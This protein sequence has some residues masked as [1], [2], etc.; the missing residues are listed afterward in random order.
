MSQLACGWLPAGGP[1]QWHTTFGG[2]SAR[3]PV[4]AGQCSTCLRLILVFA[5]SSIS[6]SLERMCCAAGAAGN[7]SAG[8]R[9]FVPALMLIGKHVLHM[10]LADV[11]SSTSAL[12]LFLKVPA[13]ADAAYN[14]KLAAQQQLETEAMKLPAS[15]HWSIPAGESTDAHCR[16]NFS[17]V[18]VLLICLPPLSHWSRPERV[19]AAAR[20][21]PF[22]VGC[23]V[24]H[25]IPPCTTADFHWQVSVCPAGSQ[26]GTGGG[27]STP[28]L[29]VVGS[30]AAS[31]RPTRASP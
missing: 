13:L 22:S 21:Y 12:L 3:D 25:C 6:C 5:A 19:P 29:D 10:L 17:A 4:G 2:R 30:Q 31:A 23:C 16:Q 8:C 15:S 27:S 9:D 1:E 14:A 7:V 26:L 24:L 20:C 28:E 11:A 18:L